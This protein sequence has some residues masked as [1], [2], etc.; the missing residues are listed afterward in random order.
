MAKILLDIALLLFV[1]PCHSTCQSVRSSVCLS[2]R[3]LVFQSVR[4]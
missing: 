3:L 4:L 1:L 2:F